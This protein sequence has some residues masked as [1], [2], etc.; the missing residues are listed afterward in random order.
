MCRSIPH[1]EHFQSEKFPAAKLVTGKIIA[2][3]IAAPVKNFFMTSP[4]PLGIIHGVYKTR[5]DKLRKLL[6]NLI[7]AGV[8][9][10]KSSAPAE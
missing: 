8:A 4:L 6:F 1:C 10:V 2:A 7:D 3:T 9:E 5:H